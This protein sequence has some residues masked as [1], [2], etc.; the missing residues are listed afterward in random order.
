[1]KKLSNFDKKIQIE[2]GQFFVDFRIFSD[3]DAIFKID[4][5]KFFVIFETLARLK[6]H[7]QTF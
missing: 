6:N 1:M 3:F 5:S 2:L 7:G 4:G